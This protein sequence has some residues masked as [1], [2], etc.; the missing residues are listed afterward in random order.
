VKHDLRAKVDRHTLTD[1]KVTR[2]LDLLEEGQTRGTAA[3][4]AG[5][6]PSAVAAFLDSDAPE[7][8]ELSDLVYI[9][10]A[11][12]EAARVRGILNCERQW[13]ALA[14]WLQQ[15]RKGDWVTIDAL[16]PTSEKEMAKAPDAVVL[17]KAREALRV[18][19]GGKR[20]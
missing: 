19:E 9:A 17:E 1:E 2:M 16:K 7:A 6:K 11:G 5:L 13:Q 10:E 15:R 12:A 18:L 4:L 8:R 3:W 14:W 20:G